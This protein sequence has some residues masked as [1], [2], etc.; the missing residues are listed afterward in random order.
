MLNDPTGS[1]TPAADEPAHALSHQVINLVIPEI[2][3]LIDENR[4]RDIPLALADWH[5]VDLADLLEDLD[6]PW[7]R[8]SFFRAWD[9]DEALE[10]FEELTDEAMA[11]L[12]EGLTHRERLWL[13]N[14]MSPDERADLFAEVED[15]DRVR[16]M[17]LLSPR[18][19]REIHALL[20]YPADSA[21]GLMTTAF[22]AI[23][24]DASAEDGI[25]AVRSAAGSAETV[26][27]IYVLDTDGV[28]VGALSLRE[29]ITA[30]PETPVT[31]I[32][33][34]N[35]I[36]VRATE[37]QEE[38]AHQLRTYDLTAIPVVDDDG[39]MLGIVTVDDVLDVIREENTEDSYRLAAIT[40]QPTPYIDT[41][42]WKLARQRATWLLVLVFGGFL[43]GYVLEIYDH[44][45][46]TMVFLT[47][48]VPV[49]TG[50]GGNAGTQVST[51]IVRS[52]A[53]HEL[54]P[55]D[56]WL[57]VRKEIVAGLMVGTI[58]AVLAAGR[59]WFVDPEPNVMLTLGLTMA[60]V[61]STAVLI[62]GL[63]PLGLRKI[64]LDPALM[65][66][67]L[68]TTATDSL[69]LLIYFEIALWLL[70]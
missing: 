49:L 42:S 55:G 19:R 29:L 3:E 56:W 57:V 66:S 43:S 8:L 63:L 35:L 15:D 65:S 24:E 16:L 70:F 17:A 37:D 22:V 36:S 61:V 20:Q 12:I 11:E 23:S 25:R 53:T 44:V 9:H 67:P 34:T 40:E 59:A 45:I 13:L 46:E 5:P 47:F 1:R 68:I 69:A 27:T 52:L 50:S 26:Y 48:F 58:M 18:A 51:T 10:I 32:M 4:L 14:A 2:R 28:L 21:G 38:M 64:G 54:G 62:G 33:E 6:E 31:E 60:A 7:E 41:P 30:R 39:H